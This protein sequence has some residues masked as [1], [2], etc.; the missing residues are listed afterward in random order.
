MAYE[1]GHD[2]G[3]WDDTEASWKERNGKDNAMATSP[4]V[5]RWARK[6]YDTPFFVFGL[7]FLL[8]GSYYDS[9]SR[10]PYVIIVQTTL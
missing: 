5:F 4:A 7:A 3:H 1:T 10:Y 6:R 8:V 2:I 9:K